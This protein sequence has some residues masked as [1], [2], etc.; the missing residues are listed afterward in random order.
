MA[1]I[2]FVNISNITKEDLQDEEFI[3][4]LKDLFKN[5]ECNDNKCKCDQCKKSVL[6]KNTN[7]AQSVKVK[8]INNTVTKLDEQYFKSIDD[9]LKELLK[10][11]K[12]SNTDLSANKEQSGQSNI[13][14]DEKSYG[15][16]Y[17]IFL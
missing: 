4:R 3:G 14:N 7:T 2:S 5:T 8:N 10:K 15:M 1:D 16:F 11:V 13:K 12:K 17:K 6:D 9:C